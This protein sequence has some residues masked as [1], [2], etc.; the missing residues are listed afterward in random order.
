MTTNTET[1]EV[2]EMHITCYLGP[3]DEK[4]EGPKARPEGP[5]LTGVSVHTVYS[6]VHS[7]V[8][9][10]REGVLKKSFSS[11]RPASKD[12][13]SPVHFSLKTRRR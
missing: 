13:F 7:L 4:R 11:D 9:V 10:C 5:P 1:N 2:V 12:L 3:R 8:H 6:P